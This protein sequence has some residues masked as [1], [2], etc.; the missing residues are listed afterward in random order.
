MN[1]NFL[2]KIKKINRDAGA[3]RT[4]PKSLTLVISESQKERKK[5]VL[6]EKY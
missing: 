1:N 4:I 5:R 3:N 6:Q 2:K